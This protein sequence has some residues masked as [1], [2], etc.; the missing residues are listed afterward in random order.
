MIGIALLV[1]EGDARRPAGRSLG[2]D[3]V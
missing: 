2:K 1:G 3:S